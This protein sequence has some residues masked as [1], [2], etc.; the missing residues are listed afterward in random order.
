MR[1]ALRNALF[2]ALGAIFTA[3]IAPSLI[4]WNRYKPLIEARIEES[5]GRDVT[6]G[7]E[8][9]FAL[10]PQPKL[11][12]GD[13]SIGNAKGASAPELFRVR[14][15]EVRVALFP[16]F[17]GRIRFDG[18]RLIEPVLSL[19]RM[20]D[21]KL[22]WDGIPRARSAKHPVARADFSPRIGW[23]LIGPDA[24]SIRAVQVERG[25]FA[26]IDHKRGWEEGVEPIDANFAADTLSGPFHASGRAGARGIP[27]AFTLNLGKA[28][29]QARRSV[30]ASL[31]EP[32]RALKATLVGRLADATLSAALIV[33][34]DN[35]QA[36][37]RADARSKAQSVQAITL[38][39]A[40]TASREALSLRD[41]DIRWGAF[42]GGG[43][44]SA[45]YDRAPQLALALSGGP[46]DLDALVPPAPTREDEIAAPWPLAVLGLDW[47]GINMQTRAPSGET[48]TH[49]LFGLW[50]GQISL[51]LNKLILNGGTLAGLKVDARLAPGSIEH[52]AVTTGLPGDSG[53]A[54]EGRVQAG[55]QEPIFDG[56]ATLEGKSAR[57]LLTWLGV[58]V[59]T[60]SEK[61]LLGFA[62]RGGV[63]AAA[64]KLAFTD[65]SA[66]LDGGDAE[67]SLS[68]S[69]RERIAFDAK[70]HA[71]RLNL[72]AYQPLWRAVAAQGEGG[73][74]RPL[75][76]RLFA[77]LAR[78]DGTLA[79]TAD[80][81]VYLGTELG[82]VTAHA[83]V[84]EGALALERFDAGNVGGGRL[85]LHGDIRNLDS[86]P[87]VALEASLE[88]PDGASALRALGIPLRVR[89][90]AP[91]P[92][93]VTLA[94]NGPRVDVRL[95]PISFALGAEALEGDGSFDFAHVRPRLDLRITGGA[96]DLS[97]LLG[98]EA[99]ASA[100]AIWSDEKLA[101][102]SLGA[103]DGTLG[104]A[105]ASLKLYGIV[106]DAPQFSA[107]LE[108]G[109]LDVRDVRAGMFGG[110][111]T[112]N[113]SLRGGTALPGFGLSLKFAG[114]DAA[115][116]SELLW[117]W[118]VLSG[119]LDGALTLSAQGESEVALARA[120]S[121]SLVVKAKSGVMTGFDLD[122]F[123]SRAKETGPIKALAQLESG[124]TP[125][126]AL[127]LIAQIANGK[128]SITEGRIGLEGRAA[129]LEGGADVTQRKLSARL[130]L[131]AADS[132]DAPPA[133]IR[134]DGPFAAPD[135]S[136]D[137]RALSAYL[138]RRTASAEPRPEA[139]AVAATR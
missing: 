105:A 100:P 30:E 14:M 135:V 2:F 6:I 20:P 129:R 45:R 66:K 87:Q 132:P 84:K 7:G 90:A 37:W 138:D 99:D 63:Q 133:V 130:E 98:G 134:F 110:N 126:S 81:F 106:L 51:A 5:L 33:H 28:D 53:L 38:E 25:R 31:G 77:L 12:V 96:I 44:A 139:P 69:M 113:A 80:S 56:K 104:F 40:L 78:A 26:Y 68:V 47:R 92:M 118:P 79:L 43:E 89:A 58:P 35:P 27:L 115:P 117:D 71:S 55:A 102:Q 15:M 82:A 50:H 60:V 91:T 61:R 67:G 21:G 109:L 112:A 97:A 62:Y 70:L 125:F 137:V 128:A 114:L 72:D 76:D 131:P 54:L 17:I 94:A 29:A 1:V 32:S 23:W 39:S 136:R 64:G 86:A 22:N 36:L 4:N 111:V 16:L 46:L 74:K 8:L 34:A 48:S 101:L 93:S 42:R 11:F 123:R 10:L 24:V 121:G 95:S 41:I 75:F 9:D 83:S 13:L 65:F 108:N 119:K 19:E 52:L 124:K 122:A 103:F 18:I 120:V 49:G 3:L 88:A 85:A 107:K 57:G 116:M 127:S 73:E 59:Q